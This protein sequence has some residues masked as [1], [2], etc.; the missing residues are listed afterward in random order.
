MG[1]A[2]GDRVIEGISGRHQRSAGHDT[3][4]M[5][6][7]DSPVDAGAQTEVIGVDDETLIHPRCSR[8]ARFA[9]LA[10]KPQQTYHTDGG[11]PSAG[12]GKGPT[13]TT[14]RSDG[15]FL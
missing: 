8:H 2:E 10:L 5:G 3:L 4:R 12:V 13:P 7:D 6:L 9:A 14:T 15:E 11:H 1:E